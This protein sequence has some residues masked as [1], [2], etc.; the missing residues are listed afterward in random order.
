MLVYVR[1]FVLHTFRGKQAR[2]C[3]NYEHLFT[4]SLF[5]MKKTWI[6]LNTNIAF[7][8]NKKTCYATADR[9]HFLHRKQ[10]PL[11]DVRSMVSAFPSFARIALR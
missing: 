5:S 1:D 2:F 11:L 6:K 3:I 9:D 4:L 7:Y 8:K 10:K